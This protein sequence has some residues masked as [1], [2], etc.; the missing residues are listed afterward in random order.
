MKNKI[1]QKF[2]ASAKNYD[3]FSSLHR[4]IA[5]KLLARVIKEPVPSAFLDVGCG[6]GYFTALLKGNF[7]QSN[8]VGLDFAQGMIDAARARHDG[9]DWVL[10]DGNNLPF[11]KESFD[12]VV[13]N[14][15]YQ[16]AGYLIRV[17]N[18][19]R[20]VLVPEGTFVGTLFGYNTC[21]ELFQS[22]DEAKP[23]AFKFS[24]LPDEAQV[25]EALDLSGFKSFNVNSENIKVEF[26]DMYELI[27]WF[28][29]IGAN[30]LSREGYLGP[31]AISRAADIYR[32]KF[33]FLN[34]VG[35]TFEVI[36]FYAKK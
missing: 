35:A 19:A 9:I 10:A 16:W 20:R 2:S 17:F 23:G 13:S 21:Q 22:L 27:A 25:R 3:R 34:G 8:I 32:E 26:K 28:K 12:I 14:L 33:A 30:N 18:E 36:W 4:E 15:A 7:P 24:R 6:T 29:S 31:E 5:D 11:A 1:Q